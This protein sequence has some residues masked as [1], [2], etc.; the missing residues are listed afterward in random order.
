VSSTTSIDRG[1]PI[2]YRN[3][4]R[5][6]ERIRPYLLR[7]RKAEVETELP[8]RTDRNHFVPLSPQQ[9]A[10][11]DSHEGAVARLAQLA[12]RRPLTQQEQ[13]KLMRELAM[14]RMVCDTNYILD[15]DD[16]GVP[17]TGRIGETAGGVPRE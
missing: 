12:R 11:Y 10:E 14:M 4:E 17:Q 7:R 16:K 2:G 3:L 1:R 8:D 15:P 6:H 5:L 9:Q 13:D